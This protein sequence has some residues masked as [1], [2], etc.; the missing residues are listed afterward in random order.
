MNILK[1]LFIFNKQVE[2]EQELNQVS[3]DCFG[4]IAKLVKEARIKQNLTIH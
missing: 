2:S 4:E 1:N 3:F